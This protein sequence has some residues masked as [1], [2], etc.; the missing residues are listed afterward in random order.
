MFEGDRMAY[1]AACISRSHATNDKISTLSMAIWHA[2]SSR[3]HGVQHMP[4]SSPRPSPAHTVWTPDSSS[5]L[6]WHPPDAML[7]RIL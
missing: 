5:L 2:V 6:V 1:M 7:A 4:S 3:R